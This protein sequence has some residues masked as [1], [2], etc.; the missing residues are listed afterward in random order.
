MPKNKKPIPHPHEEEYDSDNTA[1]TEE[2][3]GSNSEDSDSEDS[4][5]K[6]SNKEEEVKVAEEEEEAPRI[7]I[8]FTPM[9]TT[10]RS[11]GSISPDFYWPGR[12]IHQGMV[13]A[14]SVLFIIMTRQNSGFTVGGAKNITSTTRSTPTLPSV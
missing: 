8:M 9:P 5:S 14:A 2:S 7:I 12:S 6:D 13:S 1:S 3:S 11:L 10:W 4:D